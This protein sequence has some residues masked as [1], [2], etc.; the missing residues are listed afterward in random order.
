MRAEKRKSEESCKVVQNGKKRE[1]RDE[2]RRKGRKK[3]KKEKKVKIKILIPKHEKSH[4]RWVKIESKM[5]QKIP[6][7]RKNLCYIND[8]DIAYLLMTATRQAVLRQ[9]T[10]RKIRL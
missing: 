6:R 3:A 5:N 1:K 9:K 10:T 4:G 2:K 8:V 7:I